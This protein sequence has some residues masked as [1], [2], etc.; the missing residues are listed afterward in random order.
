LLAENIKVD[1]RQFDPHQTR[2]RVFEF[3]ELS[4]TWRRKLPVDP[5]VDRWYGCSIGRWEGETFVVES[6]GYDPRVLLGSDAGH[7]L[8]PHSSELR[9]VERYKRMG[10]VSRTAATK[11]VL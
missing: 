4:H 1:T 2:D 6:N 9:I 8:F 3:F 11:V 10:K 5:P 7:Q